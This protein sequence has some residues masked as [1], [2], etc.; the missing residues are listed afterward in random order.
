MEHVAASRVRRSA[1]E[2]FRSEAAG[3]QEEPHVKLLHGDVP[4]VLRCA[5]IDHHE[6]KRWKLTT[7]EPGC[8]AHHPCRVYDD[9]CQHLKALRAASLGARAWRPIG[10]APKDMTEILGCFSGHRRVMWWSPVE[11]WMQP[12][13]KAGTQPT[14]WT[15]LPPL[16]SPPATTGGS[17]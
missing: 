11:G 6:D 16:P 1:E 12:S 15:S 9:Y 17:G 7:W 8:R 10:S 4:D 14:L 3:P 13:G 5:A 2:Q